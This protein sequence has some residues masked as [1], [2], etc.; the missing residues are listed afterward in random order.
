[1]TI[2]SS[3]T[4][5]TFNGP[6]CCS[7]FTITL[8]VGGLNRGIN[9]YAPNF[10]SGFDTAQEVIDELRSINKGMIVPCLCV[11]TNYAIT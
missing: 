3:L 4:H 8:F 6:Q 9:N 2:G 11:V 1:M 7:Q 5:C 10:L